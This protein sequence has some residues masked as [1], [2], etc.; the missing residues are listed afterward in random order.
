M[1]LTAD[2]IT[3]SAMLMEHQWNMGRLH[4]VCMRILQ[5][6]HWVQAQ[7]VLAVKGTASLNLNLWLCSGGVDLSG[8]V[9]KEQRRA[10]L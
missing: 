5:K 7:I 4:V 9:G 1:R 10:F 6:L 3:C 8:G 2:N